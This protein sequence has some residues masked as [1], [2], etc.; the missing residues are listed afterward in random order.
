MGTSSGT[1]KENCPRLR[2]EAVAPRGGPRGGNVRLDENAR[3]EG[4]RLE[5]SG[6]RGG[7]KNNQRQGQ[8]FA[9]MLGDARNNEDMVAG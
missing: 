8:A 2:I 1:H 4:N 9:L 6:N 5:N 7:N 3:S